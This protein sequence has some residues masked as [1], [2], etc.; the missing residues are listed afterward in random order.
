MREDRRKYTTG[1]KAKRYFDFTVRGK[2]SVVGGMLND[3]N[4]RSDVVS[5]KSSSF[6]IARVH[7]L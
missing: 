1:L 2:D 6:M 5:F 4:E 3:G 7:E